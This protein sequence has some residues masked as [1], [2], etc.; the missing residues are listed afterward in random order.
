MDEPTQIMDPVENGAVNTDDLPTQVMDPTVTEKVRTADKEE[1]ARRRAAARRRR[2]IKRM[3]QQAAMIGILVVLI[4]LIV[5][6]SKGCSGKG[7][8][9]VGTWTYGTA[10]TYTFYDDGTGVLNAIG[11]EYTFDYTAKKGVLSL[12]FDNKSVQDCS[13]SYKLTS[14]KLTLTGGEGTMSPGANYELVKK[15]EK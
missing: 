6:I 12:D 5:L 1:R 14:K 11:D 9:L 2:K 8:S 3:K 4:L 10:T 7:K 15:A 13:Y